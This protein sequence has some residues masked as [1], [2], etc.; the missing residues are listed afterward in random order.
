MKTDERNVLQSCFAK[1]KN[2]FIKK[3]TAEDWAHNIIEGSS[4]LKT[5]LQWKHYYVWLANPNNYNEAEADKLSTASEAFVL[6][7][8]S[9]CMKVETIQNGPCETIINV[10]NVGEQDDEK[11][12]L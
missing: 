2:L 11:V 7:P 8:Y 10:I 5:G 12:P 6:E 9:D 3:N 1:T 4:A